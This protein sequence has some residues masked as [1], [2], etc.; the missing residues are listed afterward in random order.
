MALHPALPAPELVSLTSQFS[1][2]RD[3]DAFPNAVG[4]KWRKL[5]RLQ[6]SSGIITFGGAFSNHLHAVSLFCRNHQI[7]CVGLVR[8]NSA[9]LGNPTLAF[10]QRMGM[11]LFRLSKAEFDQGWR[12]QSADRLTSAHPTYIRLPMGGGSECVNEDVATALGDLPPA[13][14]ERHVLIAAGSGTT[15]HACSHANCNQTLPLPTTFWAISAGHDQHAATSSFEM[16]A[17]THLFNSS[18]QLRWVHPSEKFSE[19]T[20]DGLKTIC[21]FWH[22][23][24]ILLDPIYTVRVAQ[25]AETLASHAADIIMLHSGGLQGWSKLIERVQDVQVRVA[26]ESALHIAFS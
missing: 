1:I 13:H 12:G 8:G 26:I 19:L 5:H 16:G 25:H 7:P 18:S 17:Q 4:T 10:C 24:N 20:A 21:Q 11:Q 23:Y 6:S 3:D 9:D 14:R 22:K 15:A 2:L